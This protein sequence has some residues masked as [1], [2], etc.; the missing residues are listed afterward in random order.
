MI[1][2]LHPMIVVILALILL[3]NYKI[4]IKSDTS[5]DND[6]YILTKRN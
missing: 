4:D 1:I 3:L 5:Y 6:S 2:N